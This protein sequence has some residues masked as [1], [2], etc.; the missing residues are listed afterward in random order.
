M[1]DD[2]HII[3][4]EVLSIITMGKT[5]KGKHILLMILRVFKR[6]IFLS[7]LL[8]VLGIFLKQAQSVVIQN[9]IASYLSDT[10]TTSILWA[11]LLATIGFAITCIQGHTME[12]IK[13]L[14][15]K[16][17][18]CE[19]FNLSYISI[20][21]ENPN[22]YGDIPLHASCE[23]DLVLNVTAERWEAV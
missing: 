13:S 20:T 9:I 12:T 2:K 23:T 16:Q 14:T 3:L 17:Y 21:S 15:S 1:V 10:P 7:H 6:D 19:W 18:L 8:I 22:V 5:V 11:L 4:D